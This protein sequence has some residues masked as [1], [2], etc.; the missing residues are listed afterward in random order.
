MVQKNSSP[1]PSTWPK[2]VRQKNIF[3][4]RAVEGD[5]RATSELMCHSFASIC[6]REWNFTMEKNEIKKKV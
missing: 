2:Q 5:L 4:A 3:V 6:E 1:A